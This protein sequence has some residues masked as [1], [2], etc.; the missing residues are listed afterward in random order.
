[1]AEVRYNHGTAHSVVLCRSCHFDIDQSHCS[2]V[3]ENQYLCRSP[4][5]RHRVC[6]QE[7]V[8]EETALVEVGNEALSQS[9][10]PDLDEQVVM[11]F[12]KYC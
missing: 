4:V 3:F 5:V 7:S 12:E 2:L 8:Q 6:G 9:H 10:S 1:M 11:I